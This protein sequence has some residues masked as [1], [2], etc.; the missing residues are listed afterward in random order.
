M[1]CI[2]IEDEKSGQELLKYK[3]SSLFPEIKILSI[4]DNKD[5]AVRFLENN[6]IDFIFLDIQIKG[7]TGINVLESL[8]QI[9]FDVIFTTAYNNYMEDAF[10]IGAVHYLMKPF[11]DA[12]LK[13]AIDRVYRKNYAHKENQTLVVSNKNELQIVKLSEIIYLKSDGSYTEIF[14]VNNKYISSKNMGEIEKVLDPTLFF[15]VHHSFIVN[16]NYIQKIEKNRNGN[17]LLKNNHVVPISQRKLN[18]FIK[19]LEN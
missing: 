19:Q 1:K 8:N 11:K 16:K 9:N 6:E 10:E 2:I 13:T 17:I 4:I 3:M 7:G 15:R 5:D 12:D 18:D 14:L